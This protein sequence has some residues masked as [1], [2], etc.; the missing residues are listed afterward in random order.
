M[1]FGNYLL[2]NG[3]ISERELKEALAIQRFKKEKI[4]RLLRE[5]GY[6]SSN[7]LNEALRG[8]FKPFCSENIS[9]L[10][11]TKKSFLNSQL[12]PT[13]EEAKGLLKDHK[14]DIISLSEKEVTLVGCEYQDSIIQEAERILSKRVMLKVVE[15]EVFDLLFSKK[16]ST[17]SP[18]L[19]TLQKNITDEGKLEEKNPYS[20]LIRESIDE[21]LK[22]GA[23]DIHYEPMN[24]RY[25][26]RFRINGS[27][28]DWK[29]FDGCYSQGIT[30]KLKSIFNMDPTI[31][32]QPQDSRAS[33]SNRRVDIR[34]SSFPVL[35]GKEKVVLRFQSQGEVFSL[36]KLGLSSQAY[37]V[38]MEN[39]Q[40]KE[41]LILISGPTGSG[42]TTT[43]Y[44]LL[45]KM[46]K[47]MKNISTLENPIE[48]Q[49][50][51]ITQ[52]SFTDYEHFEVFERALM[53]QD[54]DI[55]LVGEVRDA[56]SA[57]LCMR[58]STTGHLV[59]STIHANGAI[60]VIERLRS[61]GIDDF[62]IKSNL[63]LSVAQR[64]LPKVCPHCSKDATP[65]LLGRLTN[66]HHLQA[67]G[68]NTD[69][70]QLGTFKTL[71]KEGCSNCT[72]GIIGRVAVMEY[73]EK[74][75]IRSFVESTVGLKSSERHRGEDVWG[76]KVKES[77]AS[78]PSSKGDQIENTKDILKKGSIQSECLRLASLGFIDAREVFSYS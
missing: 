70:K 30:T 21:A 26:I 20:Q 22:A 25:I 39:I 53:R 32:N 42:K 16:K 13:S 63:H 46:D 49:L 54:P 15:P 62:L 5:L 77:Q 11:K 35:G 41:G 40:K 34:A 65:D 44:S 74:D 7:T 1:L 6:I 59:L 27:L 4:G 66:L 50:E 18:P 12:C 3:F 58:L 72:Q 38:L 69:S 48:K 71:N 37:Q 52:A 23:S 57:N 64:L 14:L 9:E 17:S 56:P 24:S 31:V 8:Y 55:I 61:L 36:E 29:N 19:I 45:E 73:A 68:I 43:L 10:I 78:D 2:Q 51:R 28:F 76:K 75:E 60:E 33:F 67:K 47:H